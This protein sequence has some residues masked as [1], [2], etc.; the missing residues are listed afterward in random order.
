MTRVARR[1]E[2]PLVPAGACSGMARIGASAPRACH[3]AVT[4]ARQD[5]DHVG[6]Q[7]RGGLAHRLSDMDDRAAHAGLGFRLPTNLLIGMDAH[8]GI[9]D[10]A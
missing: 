6:A 1:T 9:Y 2:R 5:L 10:C 7:L 4:R 3:G 8:A